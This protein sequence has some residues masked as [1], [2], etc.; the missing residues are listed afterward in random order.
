MKVKAVGAGLTDVYSYYTCIPLVKVKAVGA[1]LT[2][3]VVGMWNEFE[4]DLSEMEGANLEVDIDGSSKP[5]ITID[6]LDKETAIVKYFLTVSGEYNIIIKV[7]GSKIAGSPF[8]P[9]IRGKYERNS[10]L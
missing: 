2:D 9:N 1:G 7:N 8:K 4:V 6:H 3:G 5:E 10:L